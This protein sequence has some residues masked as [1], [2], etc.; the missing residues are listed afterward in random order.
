MSSLVPA[1]TGSMRVHPRCIPGVD[2][3]AN[4][5]QSVLPM[6]AASRLMNQASRLSVRGG[7][8]DS[9]PQNLRDGS[10]RRPRPAAEKR[11]HTGRET[12]MSRRVRTMGLMT[13]AM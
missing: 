12:H 13:M 10:G 9:A 1:A 11:T 7:D 8:P 3:L 6:R 5:C 4:D 2:V